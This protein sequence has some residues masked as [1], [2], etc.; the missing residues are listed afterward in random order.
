MNAFPHLIFYDGNCG[1]CQASV[2]WLIAHDKKCL[3]AFA[4]LQGKHAERLLGELMEQEPDLDSMVLLEDYQQEK[5]TPL[6]RA[7]AVLR[8]AWLLGGPWACLGVL[9][10]L[11]SVLFDWAYRLI[12]R[13]RH[14]L[15]KTSDA[16]CPIPDPSQ[17]E[18]F[19][20]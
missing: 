3:F 19:I 5:K 20:D 4:S 9:H 17:R 10:L 15:I 18:R 13:H 11:P 6:V 16:S 1:F 2:R 12:A 8:V 14:R 7:K